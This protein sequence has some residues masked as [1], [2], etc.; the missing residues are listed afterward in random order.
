M[1]LIPKKYIVHIASE[2][3]KLRLQNQENFIDKCHANGIYLLE[4]NNL[5]DLK[6]ILYDYKPEILIVNEDMY[7]QG[8]DYET[9]SEKQKSRY[10]IYK[11]ILLGN[12]KKDKSKA[13]SY[14]E[15][16]FDDFLDSDLSAEEI[17]VKCFAYLRRKNI[18]EK[19]Q[20]TKLPGINRTYEIIEHCLHDIKDWQLLHVTIDNLNQYNYMYGVK[21]VDNLIK[22]SA[23]MLADLV[24]DSDL[25]IGHLGKDNFVL[26]GS[27][28]NINDIYEELENEFSAILE[29][30]YNK[31]DFENQYIVYSAPHKVRRKEKLVTLNI[32]SCTSLDRKFLSGS[33]LIEQALL[34][35][36]NKRKHLTNKKVVII[37]EDKDFAELLVDRLELDSF[38]ASHS[39]PKDLLKDLD[40]VRPGFLVIEAAKMGLP[41]FEELCKKLNKYDGIADLNIIVASNVPGYRNFLEAG[42]NTYIPKP[43]ELDTLLEELKLSC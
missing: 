14:I 37:E 10:N 26:L 17:F 40:T 4:C 43:Y 22:Q 16:G 30:V 23:S 12:K 15:E 18:L 38:E 32:S 28:Q 3:S 33:D 8:F 20:L 9:I 34:N 2:K 27:R 24:K 21:N 19:N 35:K 29:K 5:E 31:K 1:G 25:F 39:S 13:F 42:A 11:L 36:F 6:Y 7:A 41:G